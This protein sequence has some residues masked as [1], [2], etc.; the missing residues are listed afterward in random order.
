MRTSE[1]FRGFAQDETDP[2]VEVGRGGALAVGTDGTAW[3]VSR[4]RRTVTP[5]TIDQSGL[6]VRGAARELGSALGDDLDV[7]AV[8]D[9]PVIF[10]VDAGRLIRLDAD[11][12][13]VP[14][15]APE[16]VRLQQ[17]GPASDRVYV[18][19]DRGLL[20]AKLDGGGLDEVRG[21]VD[22]PPAAPVVL[23]GYVHAAWADPNAQSYVRVDAS[24]V[25]IHAE[26]IPDVTNVA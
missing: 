9:V 13:P 24:S 18:A 2:D 23:N 20:T 10:D 21:A 3:F 19:T 5:V 6:P 4:K 14:S 16:S 26:K 15:S 17:P 8:G 25:D 22:G 12:L 11:P 7:T 1:T